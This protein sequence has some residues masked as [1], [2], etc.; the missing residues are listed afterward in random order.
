M[1]PGT[2][3]AIGSV[4]MKGLG[5]LFGGKGD[6]DAYKEY[7][8]AME[9]ARLENEKRFQA[10]LGM[11]RDLYGRSMS[12]LDRRSNQGAADI[13]AAFANEGARTMQD[14]TSR[15]L[16]GSTVLPSMRAGL[17]QR[18]IAAINRLRDSV[19]DRRIN[20]DSALTGNIARTMASRVD[21]YPTMPKRTGGGG[22]NW[23]QM[24]GQLAGA[25][26]GA[27]GGGGSGAPGKFGG[28]L[29]DWT[30]LL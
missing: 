10:T 29:N 3:L 13:N 8:K 9:R 21:S 16:S 15:G 14:L 19:L 27:F 11:Y 2:M 12:G 25:L 23:F 17:T 5:S 1:D 24:G 22:A 7:K 20:L 18:R 6:D 4:A 28:A 30:D 26:S